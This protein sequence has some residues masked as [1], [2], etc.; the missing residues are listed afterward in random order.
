LH[1]FLLLL[2]LTLAGYF[3]FRLLKLVKREPMLS[4]ED[5]KNDEKEL[6]L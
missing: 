5:T 6:L 4:I 2:L 1:T 3:E